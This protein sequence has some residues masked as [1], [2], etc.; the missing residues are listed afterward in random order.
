M[1]KEQLIKEIEAI[2]FDNEREYYEDVFKA[3][4]KLGRKVARIHL[5]H[6]WSE[7]DSSTTEWDGL[8]KEQIIKHIN[9]VMR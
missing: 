7:F 6:F 2:D 4:A 1:N 9:L 5:E 8:P 3:L